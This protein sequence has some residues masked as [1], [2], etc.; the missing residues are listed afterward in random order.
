MFAPYSAENLG[1]RLGEGF[2]GDENY[3][4][5]IY[6]W[7]DYWVLEKSTAA[8]SAAELVAGV[9]PGLL[10]RFSWPKSMRWGGTSTFVWVRPLR[11]IICLIDGAV[12]HFNLRE[13]N[14]DGHGLVSGNLTE[15]HRFHAPEL[16]AVA[17]VTDWRDRLMAHRVLVD[18]DH[19]KHAPRFGE[20]RRRVW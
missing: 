3:S 7:R 19:C 8:V 9:L 2:L 5:H 1:L 10:R 20:Q 18:A 11:R 17:G 13:V 6:G 12:V 15:G 16:F 14:D 4:P